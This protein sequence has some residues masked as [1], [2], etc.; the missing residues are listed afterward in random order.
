M[1]I[2]ELALNHV[3]GLAAD[4]AL[5]K[6]LML[7]P[8]DGTLVHVFKKKIGIRLVVVLVPSRLKT[9][10]LTQLREIKP[11][12]SLIFLRPF[13]EEELNPLVAYRRF[14]NEER[15][16]VE[17]LL[18]GVI[19]PVE[20]KDCFLLG[21]VGIDDPEGH[22]RG[23]I[24]DPIHPPVSRLEYR[25]GGGS[26]F[27]ESLLGDYE[28]GGEEQ[29]RNKE[30]ESTDYRLHRHKA[31]SFLRRKDGERALVPA[32]EEEAYQKPC[33]PSNRLS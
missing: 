1:V 6:K 26:L 11:E 28:G 31:T 9:P 7:I 8:F 30:E 16:A 10:D 4:L 14:S 18:A 2:L 22:L 3:T 25:F 20:P 29:E 33:H 5:R 21:S 24:L 13:P 12:V 19:L 23:L 15:L 32:A 27:E 17:I